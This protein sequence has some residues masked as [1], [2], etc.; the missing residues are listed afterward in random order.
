MKLRVYILLGL[1][2]LPISIIRPQE[3]E[4]EDDRA[5]ISNGVVISCGV[6][7]WSV[8]TLIG[9]DTAKIDFKNVVPSSIAYQRS[10]AA[11]ASLP[12]NNTTR[13]ASE[14]TVYSITCHLMKYK[15]ESDQDIHMEI[16][17]IGNTGETMVAEI[18]NPECPA[19]ASTSRYASLKV[20]RDWFV[21]KYN[22]TT[23]FKAANDDITI[24]G[25]GF[26]DFL[27]GQTGIPPNG[28]E[29]HPVLSMKM[30]VTDI[31]PYTGGIR[32]Y[33]LDDAYPNP[34]NPSTLIRYAVPYESSVRI[35]VYD[36]IGR[37]VRELRNE[38]QKSGKYELNFMAEN[39]ASGVY[40]LKISALSIDGRHHFNDAKKMML[41]K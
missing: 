19:I 2:L 14:D 17:T 6:E 36:N 20:L 11:P 37:E 28:R 8:K 30:G 13:L 41:V 32:D 16:C 34:F 15:L 9:V 4:S 23:S 35:T 26:F 24:S 12:G 1:L 22:P 29:I 40:F 39:L 7:R 38:I 31:E 27:H 10:L 21:A 3:D 18:L 25:V 33:S 5:V